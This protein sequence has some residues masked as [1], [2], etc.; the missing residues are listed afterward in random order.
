MVNQLITA[1]ILKLKDKYSDVNFSGLVSDDFEASV[2]IV[3][4]TSLLTNSVSELFNR[5]SPDL[6]ESFFKRLFKNLYPH[7]VF[8]K[9]PE[10]R[11]YLFKVG[12]NK[13]FYDVLANNILMPIKDDEPRVFPAGLFVENLPKL[14]GFINY[15]NIYSMRNRRKRFTF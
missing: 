4:K 9:H 5:L 1:L 10:K 8:S 15:L 13:F 2:R 3:N 11:V 14:E 12:V 6:R 7:N